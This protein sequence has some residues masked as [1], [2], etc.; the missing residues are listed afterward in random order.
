[1]LADN[2]TVQKI[3]VSCGSSVS[4]ATELFGHLTRAFMIYNL[5]ATLI[6][7]VTVSVAPAC[8]EADRAGD[9]ALM[10]KN[11]DSAAAML[12]LVS[13]PCLFG[14]AFFSDDILRFLYG[15]EV[16][17]D[18]LALVGILMLLIPFTQ[19]VSGILQAT[20]CVWPP[21]A[22]L[23]ATTLIKL[24][25]NFVLVPLMG[26]SGAALA[27]VAAYFMCCT[28]LVRLFRLRMGFGL[29]AGTFIFPLLA[30]AFAGLVGRAICSGA[31]GG[32]LGFLI[33]G[34][35]MAAVYALTMLVIVIA[36]KKQRM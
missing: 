8:A 2:F 9:S 25:L 36:A 4:A 18:V 6:A 5:P 17:G 33:G 28:A 10:R 26:V 12:S 21:I 24:A 30:A 27:T 23:G 19:V 29:R 7:A 35:V 1:M 14:C 13:A 3:L 22:V 11:A 16:H 32:S 20:G 15:G 31:G 34:G